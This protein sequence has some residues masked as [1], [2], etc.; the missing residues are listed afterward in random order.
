MKNF[1]TN[2]WVHIVFVFVLGFFIFG[3]IQ[4][5]C[6]TVPATIWGSYS[7]A[8]EY[9]INHA[10]RSISGNDYVASDINNPFSYSNAFGSAYANSLGADLNLNASSL[11]GYDWLSRFSKESTVDLSKYPATAQA[12]WLLRLVPDGVEYK[13][14]LSIKPK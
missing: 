9:I 1:F 6:M 2:I 3:R 11:E 8:S 4:G 7:I 13:H 12:E 14:L 5:F 10:G